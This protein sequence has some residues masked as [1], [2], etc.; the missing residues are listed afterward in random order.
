[1]SDGSGIDPRYAAQFQRGY[2]PA[3][4]AAPERRGPVRLEGGPP[5]TAPRVPDPPPL[6]ET[7]REVPAAVVAETDEPD[8]PVSNVRSRLEWALLGAGVLMLALATVL[9]IGAVQLYDRY[10]GWLPGFEGL[11]YGAAT[12]QLPGP[13]LVGGVLAIVAWIVLRAVS[14]ERRSS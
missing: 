10:L 9:F 7:R 14:A 2:D 12:S 13:L 1:M 11:L 6:V 8:E 4:H 5:A 3:R